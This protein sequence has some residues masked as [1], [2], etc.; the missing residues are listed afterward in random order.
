MSR[1][2]APQKPQRW[3]Y[4][5]T[6]LVTATA[7]PSHAQTS[8]KRVV[9]VEDANAPMTVQAET[10]GG[11]PERELTLERD[12]EIV[13]DQTKVNTDS[14]C[15]RQVENEVEATGNVRMV[16]FG[17]IYT[18]DKLRLN[19]DTGQGYVLNPTYKLKVNNGQGKAERVDFISE[20]VADVVSGT[21]STCE[22]P[23]PDWYLKSST[24]NLDTGRDVGTGTATIVYF[25][26]VPILG[27][28]A[29]TFSL[30]GARRSGWLP[31][32]PGYGSN[33]G[34]EL[35]VPYYVNIAPNRDLTLYPKYIGR[36]GLQLGADARYIGENDLGYY[37]GETKVEYLPDDN[38][39]HTDRYKVDSKY[40]QQVGKNLS[41]GWDVKVASDD[42]YPDDF[43][44]TA[45]SS[46]DR[47][48][49]REL[50]TD[51]RSEFW[52]LTARADNYQVLQDPDAVTDPSLYVSRPYDRLPA[53]NLHAARYDVGGFDWSLDAEAT[54]FWHPTLVRGDRIVVA[55]QVS[56][57]I[58]QPSYYI[59]PKLMLN[60][61]AYQ[62][63]N[64]AVTNASF[65]DRTLSRAIPTFSVDSGMVFERDAKLAGKEVTQT[66]EPRLFYVYTPYRDQTDFPNFDTAAATFNMAQLF[67][68]NR[69]VGSDRIADANQLTAAVVSRFL[70]P[71]GAELLR[72]TFGQRFY[73]A[74]QRV[75]LTSTTPV[76]DTRSDILLAATGRI[77]ENWTFDSA[78]EYNQ[79]DRQMETQ[80]YSFMWKPA[81]KKVLNMAY[82]YQRDSF[83]NIELSSQWPLS[84]RLYGV[85]RVSY[86]ALDKRVL[87]SLAGLEYKGSCWV[88]R[89]GSQRIVTSANKSTTSVFFQLELTGLS[90]VGLGINSLETLKK[91]IPGYQ[92]L[93]VTN[94]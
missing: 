10:I 56:F 78:A 17:D 23:D 87:E 37:S 16:R 40:T 58:I 61:A 83:K 93:N 1:F 90:Q 85:G 18:G 57:P 9:H 50:R 46:V 79:G 70:D 69:F 25:K 2:T 39:T 51:Y 30:S 67:S 66:L 60:A 19:L 86:S 64:N 71:N 82:R 11:R 41:F 26:D 20:D 84:Q 81:D 49:L 89:M 75:Q 24:L 32:T 42:A 48:L 68:E 62:L 13:R 77:S 53:I 76:N 27:T 63:D 74:D 94:P 5:L 72:L 91:T 6:A 33:G 92:A 59:T 8:Q 31:P 73:F 52:S 22:G 21:Y 3:A 47:Q 28:P 88:F 43:S 36:R 65:S 4:A 45:A 44:N 35:L 38:Q 80:N 15:F 12:V 29:L 34:F 14:A 54:R 7:V 55:P